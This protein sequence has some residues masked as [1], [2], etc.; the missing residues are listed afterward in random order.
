M[1]DIVG[2]ICSEFFREYALEKGV[3]FM[4]RIA[5]RTTHS[6]P[7]SK[8]SIL[9]RKKT[10]IQTELDKKEENGQVY[11]WGSGE[12]YALGHGID[13]DKYEP[14]LME[15]MYL[16]INSVSYHYGASAFLNSD[17]KIYTCG[18]STDYRLGKLF[19]F[20]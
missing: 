8:I 4:D 3:E 20:N 10:T 5:V 6:Q 12:S 15:M 16:N 18:A 19:S 17:G 13:E 7:K 2:F 9:K 1:I 14:S 11:T